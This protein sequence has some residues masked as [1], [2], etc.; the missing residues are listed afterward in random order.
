MLEWLLF[1][2]A[3]HNVLYQSMYGDKDSFE[4]AFALAGKH[5][6]F[7]RVKYWP[8]AALGNLTEVGL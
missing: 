3:H 5:G 2:N 8:R 4:L 6:D 7:R 1:L